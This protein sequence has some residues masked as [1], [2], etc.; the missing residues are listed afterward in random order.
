VS[1]ETHVI[2]IIVPGGIMDAFNK[3]SAPAERM[4]VPSD[5]DTVTYATADL[6]E[7]IK[8]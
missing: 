3:M 8:V 6:T 1:E 2:A 4:E 5:S 7:T